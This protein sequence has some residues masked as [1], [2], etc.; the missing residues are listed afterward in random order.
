MNTP[1]YI[2]VN[3]CINF[4]LI[5]LFLRF[6]VQF[7]EIDRRSPIVSTIYRFSSVVDVFSHIFPTVGKG[8]INLASI[9]LMLL[10]YLINVLA[11]AII[12]GKGITALELL[13]VGSLSGV[14]KFLAVLRY[15]L[16]A[17]V[18]CSW[19]V[20]FTQTNNAIVGLIMQ[21][22]EPIVAPFRRITPNIGMLDLSFLVA[23]FALL[24]LEKAITIIGVN[25]L[26]SL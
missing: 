8:R 25:I 3:M 19:I 1:S 2:L 5:M 9:V 11:N 6:M 10:L 12:L 15:T 21:L 4:A 22:A 24:L 18:V 17:S 26:Q 13:F 14:I 7:A 16:I 20:L 23:M